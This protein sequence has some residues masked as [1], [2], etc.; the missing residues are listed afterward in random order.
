[1]F[2]L[3]Q[4]ACW[5]L[6]DASGVGGGFCSSALSSSARTRFPVMNWIHSSWLPA[7]FGAARKEAD[8]SSV[9]PW[10]FFPSFCFVVSC[11]CRMA[12]VLRRR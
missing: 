11:F 4:F 10:I 6:K 5:S 7:R 3:T 1:M 9:M 8:T 12:T 2:V